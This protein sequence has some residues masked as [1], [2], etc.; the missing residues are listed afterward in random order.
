M[1]RMAF[2][3]VTLSFLLIAIAGCGMRYQEDRLQ[4]GTVINTWQSGSETIVQVA[5]GNSRMEVRQLYFGGLNPRVGECMK[6]W[7]SV[8]KEYVP[9]RG[10]IEYVVPFGNRNLSPC[11]ER[12]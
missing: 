5:V 8:W 1:K 3:A 11:N 4:E 12:P 9:L 2:R 7:V 6:I 10:K